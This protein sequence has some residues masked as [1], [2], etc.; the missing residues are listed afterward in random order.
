MATISIIIPTFNSAATMRAC[1]ESLSTQ[2]CTDFEVVI[3]D[4]L[5]TDNT[6]AIVDVWHRAHP[7][8]AVRLASERDRGIYDAMNKA[9]PRARGEWVFFLGSD[10]RLFDPE[11]LKRVSSAL[12]SDADVVYG[13]VVSA[14]FERHTGSARYGGRFCMLRILQQ[15]IC[16]Q[17]LFVRRTLFDRFGV[18]NPRFAAHADWEHNMRWFLSPQA[19]VFHIDAVIA[20]YGDGGFSAGGDPI[21]D[22]ER[23]LWYVRNGRHSLP[24]R[25]KARLVAT[26]LK[27]A[28]R[29]RD[30]QHLLLALGTC[31][32]VLY[33]RR[34]LPR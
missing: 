5:S 14:H 3:Q 11:T 19:R 18:F 26:E 20:E 10:D 28:A 9:I 13:D 7:G 21:F 12:T 4:G 1:L 33:P 15:N 8:L 17:A 29:E 23:A 22:K 27:R 31:P 16:H 24:F 25:M 34:P 32:A 2:T 30:W 6:V